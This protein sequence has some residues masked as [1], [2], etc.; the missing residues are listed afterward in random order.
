M[1]L[2]KKELL[3]L[4]M[5]QNTD[6]IDVSSLLGEYSIPTV[7]Y[8]DLADS[9]HNDD[10]K[11]IPCL[12]SLSG[13]SRRGVESHQPSARGVLIPKIANS[14]SMLYYDEEI[15][16]L[17]HL[18]S[19]TEEKSSF[20][21]SR[22]LNKWENFDTYLDYLKSDEDKFLRRRIEWKL[23]KLIAY[24][25]I[26]SGYYANYYRSNFNESISNGKLQ[27]LIELAIEYHNCYSKMNPIELLKDLFEEFR[28]HERYLVF[29]LLRPEVP[30]YKF[31]KRTLRDVIGN[32]VYTLSEQVSEYLV[33]YITANDINLDTTVAEFI[34][35]DIEE[36]LYT[37]R[38]HRFM[39][40]TNRTSN[41]SIVRKFNTYAEAKAHLNLYNPDLADFNINYEIKE[42]LKYNQLP[43]DGTDE[44]RFKL[45]KALLK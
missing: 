45:A 38:K 23:H 7:S 17:S 8:R 19:F 16:N 34:E 26:S 22:T 31:R 24:K 37:M 41:F 33:S 12:E 6:E 25:G 32:P 10:G 42:V 15:N 36:K 39:N 5:E 14:G 13:I 11:S 35:P 1:K 44:V 43:N 21:E 40:A 2:N 27:E 29:S 9:Q 28:I 3:R 4:I 18:N 20:S 30:N